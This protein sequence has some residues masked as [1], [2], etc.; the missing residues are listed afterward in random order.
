MVRRT[1]VLAA[2]VSHIVLTALHGL[3]HATIPVVVAG[4]KLALATVVVFVLPVTG[5]WV[6]LRSSNRVGALL[7]LG[8]GLAAFVFEGTL[9]FVV[10]NPDHVA[11]L[12]GVRSD[13]STNDRR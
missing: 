3:V 10:V 12:R 11:H 2:V 4:W 7:L 1:V 5:T 13:S 9:H 6:F 8:A